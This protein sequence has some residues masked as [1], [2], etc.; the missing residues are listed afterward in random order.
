[1]TLPL[2]GFAAGDIT[3]IILGNANTNNTPW[4]YDGVSNAKNCI[5][6]K[7]S[8]AENNEIYHCGFTHEYNMFITTKHKRRACY[9]DSDQKTGGTAKWNWIKRQKEALWL[10]TKNDNRK[11]VFVCCN[12]DLTTKLGYWVEVTDI[13]AQHPTWGSWRKSDNKTETSGCP[14]GQ[15]KIYYDN[16]CGG[17]EY[18]Q[19]ECSSCPSGTVMRNGKCTQ[20]CGDNQGWES[21]TSDKCVDC[22]A[23]LSQGVNFE[24]VCKKCTSTQFFNPGTQSCQEF[25]SMVQ[26]S[27]EAHNAC[28]LCGSPGALWKCFLEVSKNGSLTTP[29]L[30]TA[31]SLSGEG[32]A[33]YNL[34]DNAV[35][36]IGGN[37]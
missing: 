37:E 18:V 3:K 7:K 32:A 34:P 15:F 33:D 28:W 17:K 36:I 10:Q 13:Q 27:A 35:A 19:K 20:A 8:G 26:V 2:S 21:E 29:K 9:T 31:C 5:W 24:G 22:S 12:G 6:V 4:N 14:T 16:V 1:M 25:S 30:K 23:S 11:R